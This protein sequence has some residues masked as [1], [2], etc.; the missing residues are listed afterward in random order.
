MLHE[1]LA[2]QTQNIGCFLCFQGNMI[3]DLFHID[4]NFMCNK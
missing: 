3:N 2:S 1:S 4:L